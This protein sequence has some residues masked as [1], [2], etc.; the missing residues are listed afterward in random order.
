MDKRIVLSSVPAL[1]VLI[2]GLTSA[3]CDDVEPEPEPSPFVTEEELVGSWHR[4]ASWGS[5]TVDFGIDKQLVSTYHRD[6]D[7]ERS[8]GTWELSD[9]GRLTRTLETNDFGE[10][11]TEAVVEVERGIA[12]IVDEALYFTVLY[13]TEG[14]GEGLEGTWEFEHYSGEEVNREDSAGTHVSLDD[15]LI[16]VELTIEGDAI[17]EREERTT[18]QTTDGEP[19]NFFNAERRQGTLRAE[20][21]QLWVTY[22]MRDARE[23]P[24]DEQAEEFFGWRL[25]ADA[26]ETHAGPS[27]DPAS[28]AY[29]PL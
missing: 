28:T 1:V 21:E 27:G 7:T 15:E 4:E 23:I 26:I 25:S 19:Q 6:S 9:D 24:E 22:T 14:S 10:G 20:G 12:A 17:D 5:H 13:R 2:V 16:V 3:G 29:S 18:T 8:E 11:W